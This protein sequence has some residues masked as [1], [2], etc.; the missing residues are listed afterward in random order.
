MVVLS[1]V[2]AQILLLPIAIFPTPLSQVGLEQMLWLDS[3]K[4]CLL[5]ITYLDIW[6]KQLG[7]YM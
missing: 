6:L 4:K 5:K 3:E 2:H 1:F 7:V